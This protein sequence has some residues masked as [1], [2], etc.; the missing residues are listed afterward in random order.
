MNDKFTTEFLFDVCN[1]SLAENDVEEGSTCDITALNLS[2]Q[3]T[4]VEQNLRRR[5]SLIIASPT[6]RSS[7][8]TT[9]PTTTQTASTIA[10]SD[11][12]TTDPVTLSVLSTDIDH[13]V[14]HA[15]EAWKNDT[16][17]INNQTNMN[18]ILPFHNDEDFLLSDLL[19]RSE[20]DRQNILLRSIGN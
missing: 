16:I 2:D 12:I 4:P 20:N 5:Y 11:I 15:F 10:N 13:I 17:Q 3:S 14:Q 19:Q 6:G 18:E 8:M 7:D 9:V 1:Y